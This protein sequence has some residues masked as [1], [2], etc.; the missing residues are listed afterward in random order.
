M[1]SAR[2]SIGDLMKKKRI[3]VADSDKD[4][5]RSL[6]E[7]FKDDYEVFLVYDGKDVLQLISENNIELL[8]TDL[9]IPNVYIYNLLNKI[10]E[11]FPELPIIIMYVYCDSTQEMED[12]IR[13]IASAFFRKPFDLNELKKRIELLVTNHYI[14]DSN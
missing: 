5:C 7:F 11:K 4:I 12:T 9:N 1:K 14:L 10:K 2:H 13:K 3:L 6:Y 8:L